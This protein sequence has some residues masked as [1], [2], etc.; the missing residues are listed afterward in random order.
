MPPRCPS[1]LTICSASAHCPTGRLRQVLILGLSWQRQMLSLAGI[2]ANQTLVYD[3]CKLYAADEVLVWAVPESLSAPL[4]S[5]TRDA[6]MSWVR[7]R[8][9]PMPPASCTGGAGDGEGERSKSDASRRCAGQSQQPVDDRGCSA[10]QVVGIVPPSVERAEAVTPERCGECFPPLAPLRRS[11]ATV[12]ATATSRDSAQ[13]PAAPGPSPPRAVLLD[14]RCAGGG[15]RCD[16]GIRG[17]AV[18][19]HAEVV[20]AIRSARPQFEVCR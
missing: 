1:P 10:Q 19:N 18:Q 6:M 8:P 20:L 14:R 12:T 5:R 7:Q 4:L 13:S 2:P 15:H 17:R 3:P 16:E 9:Q 11:A